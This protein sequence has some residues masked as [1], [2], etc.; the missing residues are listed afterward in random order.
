MCVI[1][2]KPQRLFHVFNSGE[3]LDQVLK[4]SVEQ[5]QTPEEHPMPCSCKAHRS[6]RRKEIISLGY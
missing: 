1:F 3:S 2:W 4:Q 5:S 6:K